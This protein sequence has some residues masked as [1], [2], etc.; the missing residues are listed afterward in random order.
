MFVGQRQYILSRAAGIPGY[1]LFRKPSSPRPRT[2]AGTHA[3]LLGGRPAQERIGRPCTCLSGNTCENQDTPAAALFAE[4]RVSRT[5]V[6][7]ILAEWTRCARMYLP[8]EHSYSCTAKFRL[9]LLSRGLP[10]TIQDVR[11]PLVL[12]PAPHKC[13]STKSKSFQ[14]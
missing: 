5:I 8:H 3:A 4:N 11:I 2:G 1:T 14:T 13:K 6:V 10:S 9:V 7:S 12:Y